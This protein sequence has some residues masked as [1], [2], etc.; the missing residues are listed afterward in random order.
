[1]NGP[2]GIMLNEINHTEKGKCC[3]VSL[4]TWTK[5]IHRKRHQLCGSQR[6]RVGEAGTTER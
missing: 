2:E 3:V 1:M 4:Y 6:Q 5:E